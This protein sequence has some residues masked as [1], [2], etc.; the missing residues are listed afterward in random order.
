[1]NVEQLFNESAQQ[2]SQQN[3]ELEAM[4]PDEATRSCIRQLMVSNLSEFMKLTQYQRR[5]VVKFLIESID[6]LEQVKDL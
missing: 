6:Q 5:L 3:E 4:V 2:A 1:L